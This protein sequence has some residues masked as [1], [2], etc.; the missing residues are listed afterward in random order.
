[1]SDFVCDEATAREACGD[2][3]DRREVLLVSEEPDGYAVGLYVDEK[4][5]L[6]LQHAEDAWLDGKH[7]D[8]ACLATEGVSHFV[9]LMFRAKNDEEVTQLELE[10]QAEVDKYATGLLAG[11]GIGAI[12]A[13]SQELRRMLFEQV[14]YIDDETTESGRR[15]RLATRLAAR[16]AL[17]LEEAYVAKGDFVALSRAL[18]RFYRLGGQQKI[19]ALGGHS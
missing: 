11:N 16:F 9:Y 7:F 5:V 12:R 14:E 6:A 1:M 4:A 10:L 13:R 19:A 15:Y 18:R 2:G 8:A 3:V 17:H